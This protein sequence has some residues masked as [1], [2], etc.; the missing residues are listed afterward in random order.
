[1]ETNI[2]WMK[3]LTSL[4][5]AQCA[6]SCRFALAPL[7]AA[8][9]KVFDPETVSTWSFVL[10]NAHLLSTNC[11]ARKQGGGVVFIAAKSGLPTSGAS[12]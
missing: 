8:S 1:M 6:E 7:A 2:L 12:N 10:R 5:R 4:T 3:S 9:G 11:P